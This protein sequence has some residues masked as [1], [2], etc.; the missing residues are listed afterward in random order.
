MT[1]GDMS[2]CMLKTAGISVLVAWVVWAAAVLA[3]YMVFLAADVTPRPQLPKDLGWWS[4]P[5]SLLGAWLGMAVLA[6]VGQA[7]RA[8][9]TAILFCAS[10]A[11]LI[12]GMLFSKYVGAFYPRLA[13]QFQYAALIT[14]AAVLV[15]GTAWAFAAARR[16]ELIGWPTVYVA[17]SL[18]ITLSTLVVFQW[19]RAPAASLPVY[20][21]IVG[22][23]ALAAFPLAGA[24]LALS[25]N[26]NR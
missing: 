11:C 18:W 20:M 17:A 7:G 10:I 21:L 14:A 26:R 22:L 6:T 2:R 13:L 25:W 1:S 8:T 3:V 19:W 23:L 16:R 9:L 5:A 24:P 12:A 15:L 4:F